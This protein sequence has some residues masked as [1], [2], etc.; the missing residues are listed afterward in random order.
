MTIPTNDELKKMYH[1]RRQRVAAEMKARDAGAV[2]FIDSEEKREPALRY[3]T[4]HTS[5]A[6]LIIFDDGYTLLIPWDEILAK[7]NAFYDKMIP[8]TKYKNSPIDAVATNLKANSHFKNKRAELPPSTPY[9]QFLKYV[10]ALNGIDVRCHENSIH[11]VVVK[12]RMCKDSYEIACTREAARVGDLIIDALEPKIRAGEIKTETDVALFIER[13]CRAHGC[14]RTGFDTLAAGPSRSWAI[15]CFPNYTSGVWPGNGLNI[16]DF[17]VVYRGYTSDTT[18]TVIKG[19]QSAEQKKLV[20]LVKKAYDECLELYKPGVSVREAAAK[21][22]NVFAAAKMKMPHTLGH[23]V[24]LEIHEYPRVSTKMADDVVFLPGMIV[25]LEP[26]LYDE[27]AGGCRFE[28]DIL[29]T[30]NGNETISNSR[31]ITIE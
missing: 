7:Q 13:E 11:D 24:G 27:N 21:A 28:N 9:P 18:V 20:Q 8:Y 25:T 14:E 23:G 6:V 22:D 5:D 26:G 30:E 2:V 3:L 1:E 15:H 4:G 10:D 29:I 12:M 19:K 31:I 16:L 17:G